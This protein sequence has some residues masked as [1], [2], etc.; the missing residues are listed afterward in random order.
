MKRIILLAVIGTLT[1]GGWASAQKQQLLNH[2]SDARMEPMQDASCSN[3]SNS[4]GG[5]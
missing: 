3:S 2:L 4:S 5:Q 1:L